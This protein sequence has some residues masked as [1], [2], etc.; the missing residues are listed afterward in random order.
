MNFISSGTQTQKHNRNVLAG[1]KTVT[2]SN[3]FHDE[4]VTM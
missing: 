3:D 1:S 4:K 2:G